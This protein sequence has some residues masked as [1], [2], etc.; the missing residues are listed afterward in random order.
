MSALDSLRSLSPQQRNTVIAA[1]LGWTLDAFDFFILV[2]VLKRIAEEFHTDV[3][4]VSVAIFLTLAMRAL[5]ALIFG[6]AADRFGRRATLM[7]D[8]LLYSIF[9]FLTGFST[10]LTMFLILRAL[11]G[12]AMGGEWGVGAS[13]TMETVPEDSRGIVSGILQ[14]GYPSGYL[15]ASIVFFLLFPIIGWRGMFM[16]GALPALLVLYIRRSVEESPAFLRRQ[17]TPQR[18]FI[19]VLRENIPLFLWAVVL[20]T[21]F[22]FFSHGTQDLYPTFLEV[23][24]QY[25]SYTVGAIAIVYNIGAIIGGLFFGALSQR[26]GRRRAIVIA[27]VLTIPVA[28]LWVYAP[29]PVLLAVGAFLMQFF[30]QGAWGIVPVHLNELSP[31]EVRGTFPGVAYQL[32]NLFASGNATIQAGLAARWNGD[33]AFAL[34]IVLIIVA[35]VVALFSGFGFEKKDIRFGGKGTEEPQS[36][37]PI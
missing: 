12:I 22:N 6:L 11:F 37:M 16:V 17:A 20:M 28:P 27:S 13:L 23:Q 33:Y 29:G 18:S 36:A 25:R 19:T 32:G 4:T 15:L 10:G 2:F 30:V 34:M 9:E 14:A 8:V 1:Y 26:I 21:A 5:G 35:V 31:D 7:A 24:R 3:P